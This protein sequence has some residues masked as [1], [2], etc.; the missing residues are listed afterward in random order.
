[1]PHFE[2]MLYDQAQL[3]HSYLD[4]YQI[5]RDE[6]FAAVARGT[7]DYVLRDLTSPDGGFY[8]AEDAD[9][10]DPDDERLSAEGAFYVWKKADIE[11]LLSSEEAA[12][13]CHYYSV[14]DRGNALSDPQKEFIDKNILFSSYTIEQTAEQCAVDAARAGELLASAGKKLLDARSHRRRPHLDDKI[15]TSWNGLMIGAFARASAVFSDPAYAEAAVK[16]AERIHGVLYDPAN[17]TLLR[18]YRDGE[19][20]HE[21]H[22][23]DYAF[24]VSG[25]LDLYQSTQ[26]LRWLRWG[27]E[28]TGSMITLFWDSAEG[29]FYDTSGRDRSVLVR[30]KETYDGAEPTGNSVAVM[31]LLR[32]HRLIRND[33]YQSTAIKSLKY[34]CTVLDLSPQLMP[35][36]MSAVD[37][38][39]SSPEHLVLIE[40]EDETVRTVLR[41]CR[42]AYLPNLTVVV[43]REDDPPSLV[44]EGGVVHNMTMLEGKSTMYYCSDFACQAPTTDVGELFRQMN[45]VGPAVN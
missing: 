18:R 21:A 45:I 27:N 2:K 20:K 24:L 39:H 12:V 14:A 1:V 4:A 34:F 5:T 22:L 37:Y 28:L 25:L 17:R 42:S 26:D 35:A 31:N 11:R 30:T 15:L 41:T 43:I 32:L 8:S 7:L 33:S 13:F 44:T 16:G 23:D 6:T 3:V 36:M 19:A 29:G 10:I 9:S 40:G 38:Y